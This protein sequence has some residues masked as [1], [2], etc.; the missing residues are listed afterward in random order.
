MSECSW[1]WSTRGTVTKTWSKW[2][3]FDS[4]KTNYLCYLIWYVNIIHIQFLVY[5]H[6]VSRHY[7][8]YLGV[9]GVQPVVKDMVDYSSLP[10]SKM[11]LAVRQKQLFHYLFLFTLILE[12]WC[13]GVYLLG[14]LRRQYSVHCHK[15]W[16]SFCLGYEAQHMLHALGGRQL[17]DWYVALIC[18][19]VSSM[20]LWFI[21]IL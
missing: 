15:Q 16:E 2:I 14:L 1:G 3:S 7:W 17:R 5:I 20:G 11:Y 21:Q 19:I 8:H 6:K 4:F 12:L 10:L 9:Q 13:C 18:K